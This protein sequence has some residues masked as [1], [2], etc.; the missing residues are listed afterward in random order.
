M[1]ERHRAT[2]R[3]GNVA[4]SALIS[5]MIDDGSRLQYLEAQIFGGAHNPMISPKDIGRY[6][7]LIAR[8]VLLKKGI[9][10]VSEDV[11]GEKGRKIIFHTAT[12]E[13]AVLKVGAIRRENWY[14][15]GG[16]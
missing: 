13:I 12:N 16:I 10:I 9:P 8:K 1:N 14:P 15:F 11:G 7:I 6:N 2:A 4:I 5:M 3:Y